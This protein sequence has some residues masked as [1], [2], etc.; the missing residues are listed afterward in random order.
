[1]N[2]KL[3]SDSVKILEELVN[4]VG[5]GCI[6]EANFQLIETEVTKI[7]ENLDEKYNAALDSLI[8]LQP[9]KWDEISQRGQVWETELR[10]RVVRPGSRKRCILHPGCR[11]EAIHQGQNRTSH[12]LTIKIRVSLISKP[13]NFQKT[14]KCY[15][16]ALSRISIIT[17]GTKAG[18]F[19]H[20][21]AKLHL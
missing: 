2:I 21:C 9:T 7:Y 4:Q 6:S 11:A 19:M 13:V 8:Q 12:N 18:P 10:H 16:R 5:A 1:M 3:F 20:A 17:L 15:I 14:L